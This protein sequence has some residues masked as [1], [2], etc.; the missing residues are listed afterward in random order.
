MGCGS[1]TLAIPLARAGHELLA[2]DFSLKMLEALTRQAAEEGLSAIRTLSLDFNASWEQWEAAGITEGCV[3]VALASRSTMVDDLGEAFEKLERAARTRVVVTMATEFGPR[4]TRRMGRFATDDL[5]VVPDFIFALNLLL[6]NGRYPE[7]RFI[8]S[9]K[10]DQ[11]ATAQG[12][13]L[14]EAA[15]QSS[16][17]VSRQP[18]QE[19]ARQAEQRAGEQRAGEQGAGRLIRWAFI[20]WNP[21][22][23]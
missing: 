1:G 9:Y 7:L 8:D 5:E 4:G 23:P 17:G 22:F 19:N 16:Q 10:T 14:Q 11:Q 18:A 20:S 12:T 15:Q 3:D 13:T 6:A 2:A 21:H